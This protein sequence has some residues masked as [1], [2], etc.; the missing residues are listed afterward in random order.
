VKLE[1]ENVLSQESKCTMNCFL[2]MST[3]GGKDPMKLQSKTYFTLR[4]VLEQDHLQTG[5]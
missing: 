1:Y 4:N 3:I 2:P 5:K